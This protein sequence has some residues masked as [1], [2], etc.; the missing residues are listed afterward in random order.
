MTTGPAR[1]LLSLLLSAVLWSCSSTPTEPSGPVTG[2]LTV[3]GPAEMAPGTTAQ[4]RAVLQYSDGTS[5]DLTNQVTWTRTNS[6][7]LAVTS[8]GLVSGLETG[9][10]ELRAAFDGMT[11]S[12][13]V[14]VVPDG[15]FRLTVRVL[16]VDLQNHLISPVI[17]ASLEDGTVVSAKESP[18]GGRS[19]YG[20]RGRTELHVSSGFFYQPV[21][22][23]VEVTGH[24]AI[25]VHLKLADTGVALSGTYVLTVTASAA[26]AAALPEALRVRTYTASLTQQRDG[27]LDVALAGGRFIANAWGGIGVFH[28]R[29]LDSTRVEFS[30]LLESA[31]AVIEALS[32]PDRAYGLAVS[33]AATM[34]DGR[35]S[36]TMNGEIQLLSNPELKVIA[37]CRASDHGFTL[38]RQ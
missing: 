16:D 32:E 12:T 18:Q 15:T 8:R 5:D 23:I 31:A 28:G 26:C 4:F 1:M 17:T 25:D 20:V 24:Q 13:P 10:G 27:G 7:A 2:R 11:S 34:S 19:L 33:V 22:Q 36:G 6:S 35:M 30:T 38:T 37:T 3:S 29:V 9:E 21:V 14:L